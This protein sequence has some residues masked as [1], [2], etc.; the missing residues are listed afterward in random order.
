MFECAG[1]AASQ[2]IGGCYRLRLLP[3][4]VWWAGYR[5]CVV[6]SLQPR[7]LLALSGVIY[8]AAGRLTQTWYPASYA[9]NVS[10]FDMAMR[11]NESTGYPGFVLLL[12]WWSSDAHRRGYR[13]Y[14]GAVVYPFGYGLRSPLHLLLRVTN[15]LH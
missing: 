1:A 6:W 10:M 4:A 2:F 7:L 8:C 14:D 9:L 15:Q 13:F 12:F 5:R 11:P 3:G